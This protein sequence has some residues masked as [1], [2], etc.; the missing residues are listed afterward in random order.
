MIVRIIAHLYLP[1][2]GGLYYVHPAADVLSEYTVPGVNVMG[3]VQSF[4]MGIPSKVDVKKN[5][6]YKKRIHTKFHS[7]EWMGLSMAT[8]LGWVCTADMVAHS[9]LPWWALTYLKVRHLIVKRRTST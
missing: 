3:M 9:R 6:K 1:Q 4:Q 8:H 7:P 2:S 5:C